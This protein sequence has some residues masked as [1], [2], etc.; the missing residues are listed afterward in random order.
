MSMLYEDLLLWKV[1]IGPSLSLWK[2]LDT[3]K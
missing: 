2:A 3:D 1:A